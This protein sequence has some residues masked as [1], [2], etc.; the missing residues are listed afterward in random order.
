[1]IFPHTSSSYLLRFIILSINYMCKS[2]H[3][4]LADDLLVVR[5]HAG[6]RLRL[7]LHGGVVQRPSIHVHQRLVR[8]VGNRVADALVIFPHV[9]Q[10]L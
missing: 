9:F 10:G 5:A 7:G 3:E 6:A 1:M 2:P 4:R 8:S